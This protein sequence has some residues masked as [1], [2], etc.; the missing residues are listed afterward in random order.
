M[1]RPPPPN[2]NPRM[3]QPKH[4]LIACLNGVATYAWATHV[5]RKGE[6]TTFEHKRDLSKADRD[7]ANALREKFFKKISKARLNDIQQIQE[8]LTRNTYEKHMFR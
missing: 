5:L 8:P 7:H 2:E 6:G 4:V 1:L 3:Q